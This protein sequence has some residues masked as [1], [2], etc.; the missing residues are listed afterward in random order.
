MFKPFIVFLL[1]LLLPDCKELVS[2][3]A[4][5]ENAS[6]TSVSISPNSARILINQCFDFHAT[7]KGIGNVD[8]SVVWLLF[9]SGTL[10]GSGR[11]CAPNSEVNVLV[12]C[13]SAIDSTRVDTANVTVVFGL[14]SVIIAPHSA[15]LDLVETQQFTVTVTGV[16]QN[17]TGAWWARHGTITNYGLY[18]APYFQADDIVVFSSSIDSSKSDTASVTVRKIDWIAFSNTDYSVSPNTDIYRVRTDGAGL[19]RLTTDLSNDI[20]PDWSP[21]GRSIAFHRDRQTSGVVVMNF[22]GSN[23]HKVSPNSFKTAYGPRWSPDA[24]K[25]AF[26]YLSDQRAGIGLMNVDGSNFV[27]LVSVPCSGACA[28]PDGPAWSP[29]GANIAFANTDASIYVINLSGRDVHRVSPDSIKGWGPKWSPD[30]LKI[31]FWNNN[32]IYVMAPDGTNLLWLASGGFPHWSR[33]GSQIVYVGGFDNASS[34]FS[35]IFIMNADGTNQH[36]VWAKGSN[37]P[38]ETVWR[39]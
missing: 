8:S 24:S 5:P 35:S 10:S 38:A 17:S 3:T 2:P 22:D 39:P 32:G 11:Y 23:P 37:A 28:V 21:D 20:N 25:F 31:I 30:G 15:K 13:R 29:D 36:L 9:G 14:D 16:N 18:T 12:V 7:V 33:D 4:Q 34:S 27:D 6:I 1:C 19:T 26:N